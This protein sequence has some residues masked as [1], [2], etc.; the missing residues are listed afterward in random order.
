MALL[1]NFPSV[2]F[3]YG[4]LN[5]LGNE[6]TARGIDRP[7]IITD[8][9]LVEHGACEK[10]Q[11]ALPKEFAVS[12]FGEIPENPTIAG[13]DAALEV[14]RANDCNGII[15]LGGGSVLD[16]GKALRIVA[17][18]GGHVIDYLKDP[19][20]IL[21]DVA[22]YITVPTT[23]GTGAEVTFGGGI[24]P[25][26]NTPAL[27]IRSP[28]AKPDLAICDPDMTLSLP[29]RL[30]AATGMDALTHCV[31]GYL[32]TNLNPPTEAIALDGIRR[33]ATY[34]ER[35][36]NDGS[37]KE[38]REAMMM[39]ALEGGMSIYMGLGPIHALSMA[40]GDSPL[41]HGT[42]VTVAMPTVMRFDN[43]LEGGKLE[44]IAAAMGL[45]V[46]ANAGNRIA[47]KTAELNAVMGLPEN[48]RQMGYEKSDLNRMVD[49]AHGSYFNLAAPIIPTREDYE[50]LLPEVLGE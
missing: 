31:E 4:A 41:H 39:A 47:D 26:T 10:L 42:L 27:G 2:H 38:A 21:P 13:I 18:Q 3:G 8:K 29:P 24:H 30:T 9:G 25:E 36:F 19:T 33:V 11:A 44:N 15:G 12:V 23:A 34:V 37:D 28:H 45:K 48:V 1:P 50:K 46:D 40:F 35:A 17:T 7:L 49:E 43:G 5:E 22:P 32:S 6:L 16:S 20:K 14:Y